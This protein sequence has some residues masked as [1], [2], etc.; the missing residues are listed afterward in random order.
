MDY[1]AKLLLQFVFHSF[2][3]AL[4]GSSLGAEFQL[5]GVLRLLQAVNLFVRLLVFAVD[6][7]LQ[8]LDEA[9][10]LRIPEV[11]ASAAHR[12]DGAVASCARIE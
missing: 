3:T 4:Y 7:A 9:G 11:L 12:D 5:E 1:A 10:P 6:E 2:N 8:G